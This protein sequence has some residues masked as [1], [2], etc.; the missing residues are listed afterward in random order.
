M[1]RVSPELN[2]ALAG[3][4]TFVME[5]ELDADAFFQFGAAMLL[6]DGSDLAQLL[7]A[8]DFRRVMD[9]VA[10]YGLPE[11]ALRKVKPWV[12]LA[13]VSQPKPQTGE[14]MDLVLYR[15][16]QTAGKRTAGLETAAEQIAVFNT[17]SMDEQISLLRATLDQIEAVPRM[18]ARL[19]ATYLQNDLGAIESLA[20][21]LT[22]GDDTG[23]GRRF[24]RRINEER[25]ARM[26]TRMLSHLDRGGAFVAVG[27]LHLAGPEGLV[28]QL[29]ARGFEL[30]PMP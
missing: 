6:T 29:R 21:E 27:A 24:M 9:A 16:A 10:D 5:M 18:H 14:I 3:A 7:G 22:P 28:A 4:N 15:R 20:R 13:M 11:A 1:L 26:L 2:A 17:L 12:V 19:V 30:T 25:N 23:V 8:V